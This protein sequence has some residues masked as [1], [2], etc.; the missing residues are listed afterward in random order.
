MVLVPHGKT[1]V[2]STD[3]LNSNCTRNIILVKWKC[4][5]M[6]MQ[7]ITEKFKKNSFELE[8]WA[9]NDLV[10]G[11]DE[12]GRG[13]LAGP[14]VTAA[15]VLFPHVSHPL[16]RDS[17]ELTS[18]ELQKAY[19]WLTTHSKFAT[20]NCNHLEIDRVNIYQATRIAMDQALVNLS[21]FL[22]KKP[23]Y[24]L[25]D[26]VPLIHNSGDHEVRYFIK[27]ERK[28]TS[29]AAASIIA[30]VTRDRIMCTFDKIF[31]AY[32]FSHHKGYATKEHKI[33][34]RNFG[35]SCIHRTS[36]ISKIEESDEQQSIC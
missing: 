8:A 15:V 14:V 11:I 30:K 29:I 22:E 18:E 26:A 19:K 33:A 3:R 2:F 32:G 34:V 28:S 12:V 4:D 25:I 7:K 13:C 1:I 23:K 6:S 5:N 17:K 10:V 16:L 24:V 27:G 35:N 21:F 36:F 9:T 20:A 31:P